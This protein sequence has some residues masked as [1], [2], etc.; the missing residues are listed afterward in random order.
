MQTFKN[1]QYFLEA[2]LKFIHQLSSL[3]IIGYQNLP[4]VHIPNRWA[5]QYHGGFLSN[6]NDN[7]IHF[8]PIANHRAVATIDYLRGVDRLN[9]VEF[10]V[11]TDLL[12]FFQTAN[13]VKI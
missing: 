3:A 12:D 9:S 5:N 7:L 13:G 1:Y 2:N 6:K 8:P 11:N 10:R 4:M